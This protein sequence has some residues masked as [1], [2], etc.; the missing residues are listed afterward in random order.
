MVVCSLGGL[1][2]CGRGGEFHFLDVYG[3]RRAL[4]FGCDLRRAGEC[5]SL[6]IHGARKRSVSKE[7]VS[8]DSAVDR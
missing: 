1:R 6:E 3:P 2:I 8:C 4:R 7:F 5:W